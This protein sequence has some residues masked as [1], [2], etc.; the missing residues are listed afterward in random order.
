MTQSAD[1]IGPAIETGGPSSGSLE[2]RASLALKILAVLG[3]FSVVLAMFPGVIP[4]ST[5]HT[6]MVTG[7]AA[8][9]AAVCVAEAIGLDHRRPWAVAAVRP[10]LILLAASGLLWSLVAF[11]EGRIRIPFEVGLSIWA[12]LGAPDATPIA[13]QDRRSVA[14]IGAATALIALMS[15]GQPLF[16]WGGILDVHEPDLRASL[17]ADCAAPGAGL[18]DTITITYDWAWDA[19]SPLP[20]GSDIGVVGWTGADAEGHPLYVIADIPETGFG[21]RSGFGGYPSTSMAA[22]V[23]RESTGSFRWGIDLSEQELKPGRVSL[24]LMRAREI[25]PGPNPLTI[26]ATY[27]HLGLWRHDAPQVICSW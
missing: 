10:L 18:P 24:K 21:V 17:A 1:V 12:W 5:L 13:S 20:S 6:V 22:Q 15:F 7:A 11:G 9:L 23:A 26:T 16:G 25:P 14:T 27:I 2:A 8:A 3:V 4:V 19:R